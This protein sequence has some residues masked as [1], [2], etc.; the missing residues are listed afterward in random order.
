MFASRSNFNHFCD[1]RDSH[2]FCSMQQW[3][4]R[5][6][7]DNYDDDHVTMSIVA[8]HA[9]CNLDTKRDICQSAK[10]LVNRLCRVILEKSKKGYINGFQQRIGYWHK[11]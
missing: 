9:R 7:E 11:V 5:S 1:S 8:L 3:E 6:E 10:M 4:K 2:D